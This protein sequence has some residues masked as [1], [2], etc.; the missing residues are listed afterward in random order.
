MK[1]IL[2]TFLFL[3]I[4]QSYGQ[5]SIGDLLKRYNHGNVPYIT[6]QEVKMPKTSP[7][8]LDARE[9]YEFEVSHIPTSVYIGS[10][11][12]K[13]KLGKLIKDNNQ[14]VVVYCSVGIRSENIAE[15]IR[16]LGYPNVHNLYGGIFEWKNEGYNLTNK[17]GEK[18]E[19][20]HTYSAKWQKF[21]KKGIPVY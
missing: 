2:T 19:E 5:D 17:A 21:L 18:T 13:N 10:E 7:I 11:I 20:V 3:L 6:V 12:N 14:L 1:F 4:S 8:I 9:I 16:Q 15:R